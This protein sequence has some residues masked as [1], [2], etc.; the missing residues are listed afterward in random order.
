[1]HGEIDKLK[2]RIVARGFQ[3]QQ[4]IDYQD[5]FAPVARW[6]TILLIFALA[7]QKG[8]LLY[9]MDV[10]TAFLNGTLLE[11]IYM[12]IP[13]GFPNAGDITKVCKINKALYGLKQAPK[14][15]YERIDSWLIAQGLCRS[16][17]DPNLYYSNHNGK[18]TILLLYVDDLLIT[19][20]NYEEI[21]RLKQALH[22]EFEM[23]DLGYATNYLGAE[24]HNRSDIIFICQSSYIKKLLKKFQM[25]NCNSTRLSVNPNSHLQKQMDSEPID[26]T[27]YKSLV[28]SLRYLTNTRPDISYAVECV[29]HFMEHPEL[30]HFQAAQKI[31]R[32]LKGTSN[33]GL[34]LPS[35]N[36]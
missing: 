4:G 3:Q 16:S 30:A 8:W 17:T 26:H 19:G 32:Y 29:S 15:W 28:G 1:M 10:I 22:Q 27:T 35:R 18:I 12:E 33:Y 20:D 14:A 11:D 31:L 23:T 24:I 34:F 7:V 9:Q 21:S 25:N 2:A 36:T 5:I 6:S 13:N